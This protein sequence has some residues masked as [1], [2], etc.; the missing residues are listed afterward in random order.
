MTTSSVA[1]TAVPVGSGSLFVTTTPGGAVVY[2][3]DV[4]WGVSLATIP[5]LSA[6]SHTRLL[7]PDG[8]QDLSTPVIITAGVMNKFSTGMIQ[9]PVAGTVIPGTTA[10]G[11][12]A[13]LAKIRSS[14]F[15]TAAVF[16]AMDSRIFFRKF[17][18]FVLISAKDRCGR[19]YLH[20]SSAFMTGNVKKE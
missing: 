10:A 5:G 15:E 11:I 18:Y 1:G 4:P 13:A 19:R 9:L 17:S 14:G 20:R 7:K 16:F 12:P 3:D 2:I 6:G 8:Y